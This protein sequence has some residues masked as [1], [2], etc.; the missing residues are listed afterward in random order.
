MTT[1]YQVNI[2]I[3]D[4][5]IVSDYEMVSP[6][7]IREMIIRQVIDTGDAQVRE[8]L[9]KLGWTPPDEAKPLPLWPADRQK[10]CK[11]EHQKWAINMRHGTCQDC[12]TRLICGNPGW[13]PV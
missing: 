13:L 10:V 12:G 7:G 2:S 6:N 3:A 8:A 11:H 5:R 9:I 1:S 4:K